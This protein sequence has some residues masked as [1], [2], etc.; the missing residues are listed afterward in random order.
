[1]KTYI[2]AKNTGKGFITHEDQR[3]NR[4][5]FRIVSG[6]KYVS[7]VVIVGETDEIDKWTK[8]VN[9][10][11]ISKEKADIFGKAQVSASKSSRIAE[12]QD[13]LD[14]EENFKFDINDY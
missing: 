9:G 7:L 1:M 2:F 11:K 13:E 14:R 6:D 10:L 5:K 12:K 8:R 3:L 4:L